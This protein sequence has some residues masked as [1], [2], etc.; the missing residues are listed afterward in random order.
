MMV[1]NWDWV[2]PEHIFKRKTTVSGLRTYDSTS[3]C[4]FE[5]QETLR[6][7][8]GAGRDGLLFFAMASPR[9]SYKIGG[10][11]FCGLRFL[12]EALSMKQ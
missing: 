5:G 3:L 11:R 1:S 10:L 7:A 8:R 2:D 9:F 4:C 6:A 12:K